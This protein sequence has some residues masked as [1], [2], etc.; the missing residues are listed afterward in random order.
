MGSS[1]L[2][3]KLCSVRTSVPTSKQPLGLAPERTAI[4]GIVPA[5][6]HACALRLTV[7]TPE[8]MTMLASV[9]PTK[10]GGQSPM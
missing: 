3:S 1:V 7:L 2:V 8:L 9:R 6:A 10:L 4:L 5:E